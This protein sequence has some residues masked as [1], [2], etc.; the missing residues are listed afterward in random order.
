MEPSFL[1]KKAKTAFSKIAEKI[2]SLKP[3]ALY[4]VRQGLSANKEIN[5]FA[6]S[7]IIENSQD[8][9]NV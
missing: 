5:S 9:V 8:K 2:N 1:G 4:M 3:V 6:N 7:V